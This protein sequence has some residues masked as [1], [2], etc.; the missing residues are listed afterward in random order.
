MRGDRRTPVNG[1]GTTAVPAKDAGP[2]RTGRARPW[3]P[4]RSGSRSGG[5]VTPFGAGSG[6]EPLP[7]L[8]TSTNVQDAC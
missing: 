5:P 2:V 6:G 1:G 4:W 8:P 7:P 3:R